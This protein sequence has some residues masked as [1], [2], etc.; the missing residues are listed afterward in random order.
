MKIGTFRAPSRSDFKE[1][2]AGL[3]RVIEYLAKQI[4]KTS[5][6]LSRRLDVDSNLNSQTVR[7]DLSD[8]QTVRLSLDEIRGPPRH[9]FVTSAQGV[10]TSTPYEWSPKWIIGADGQAEVTVSFTPAPTELVRTTL[11]FLGD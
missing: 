8:S 3:W 7:L 2:P 5:Q 4:E 11:L 6:A 10:K 9:L 1:V